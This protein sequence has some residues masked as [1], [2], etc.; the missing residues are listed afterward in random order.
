MP[1][2][3]PL[4]TW[5]HREVETAF[6]LHTLFQAGGQVLPDELAELQATPEQLLRAARTIAEVS[7]PVLVGVPAGIGPVPRL[8]IA[9]AVVLQST[10]EDWLNTSVAEAPALAFEHLNDLGLLYRDEFQ[11]WVD[12]GTEPAD[13][14]LIAS[15][16]LL[17]SEIT[18]ARQRVA[19]LT[20]EGQGDTVLARGLA[21]AVAA[22]AAPVEAL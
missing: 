8:P 1:I 15:C 20:A 13:V 16:A 11:A 18:A 21:G 6:D 7:M 5:T 14:R 4:H 10:I 12:A 22:N 19:A 9:D 3:Q 17:P 2:T